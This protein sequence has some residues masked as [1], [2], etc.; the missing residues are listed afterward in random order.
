LLVRLLVG[1]L[2]GLLDK[3]RALL[4]AL[5]H[6]FEIS[7]A[8]R[9]AVT[10]DE[11]PSAALG[12]NRL[13]ANLT[14]RLI[15]NTTTALHLLRS[16]RIPCRVGVSSGIGSIWRIR[17]VRHCGHLNADEIG[18]HPLT[19]T[20]EHIENVRDDAAVTGRLKAHRSRRIIGSATVR[21]S[22]IGTS[23]DCS[24]RR[25]GIG[26]LLE[27]LT[28]PLLVAA[29]RTVVLVILVACVLPGRHSCLEDARLVDLWWFAILGCRLDHGLLDVV[30]TESGLV[31]LH[32]T[33]ICTGTCVGIEGTVAVDFLHRRQS[34]GLSALGTTE[35]RIV[36][37]LGDEIGA[38]RAFERQNRRASDEEKT[39]DRILHPRGGHRLREL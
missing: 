12:I 9:T 37:R 34:T 32:S 6:R 27:G 35:D 10:T 33:F 26:P 38:K 30:A 17:R 11:S 18:H 36:R 2:V 1:L 14:E 5:L 39:A 20:L 3:L 28:L 22:S 19:H 31:V 4:L 16:V 8:S 7:R 23:V 29:S 25:T 13:A 24:I 21:R 15:A